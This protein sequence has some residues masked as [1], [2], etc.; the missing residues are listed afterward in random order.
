MTGDLRVHADVVQRA[1]ENGHCHG[2]GVGAILMRIAVVVPLPSGNRANDQPYQKKDCPDTHQ[3]LRY[4][5]CHRLRRLARLRSMPTGT[6]R[7][8]FQTNRIGTSTY[9]RASNGPLS[10]ADS[11]W[12]EPRG[13]GQV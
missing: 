10:W 5:Q 9:L 3:Y 6:L 8:A 2:P 7:G 12:H 13:T 4:P 11:P 1:R